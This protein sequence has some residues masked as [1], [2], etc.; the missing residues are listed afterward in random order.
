[1]T[2]DELKAALPAGVYDALMAK[3]QPKASTDWQAFAKGAMKS[4]TNWLGAL[5]IA[6]PVIGPEVE[7]AM[8]NVLGSAVTNKLISVVGLLVIL[9]R[10][11]TTESLTSKGASK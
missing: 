2:D 11:K 10:V 4:W 3:I 9:L 8:Q 6:W 5:L 7:P 1:M